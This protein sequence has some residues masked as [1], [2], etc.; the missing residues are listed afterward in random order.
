MMKS[1]L[2]TLILKSVIMQIMLT[3]KMTG[4]KLRLIYYPQE[5]NIGQVASCS[6]SWET[7]TVNSR[8]YCV[9]HQQQSSQSQAKATCSALNAKLPVPKDQDEYVAFWKLALDKQPSRVWTGF[10]LKAF[11]E[12]DKKPTLVSFPDATLHQIVGQ[13]KSQVMC[14]QE[15]V[16]QVS[17]ASSSSVEGSCKCAIGFELHKI[18]GK[19]QCFRNGKDIKKFNYYD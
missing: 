11:T 18:D 5:V 17:V 13:F 10:K 2:L 19:N 3:D 8:T 4:K 12:K 6:P 16:S 9:K 14:V 1:F 15:V 7:M